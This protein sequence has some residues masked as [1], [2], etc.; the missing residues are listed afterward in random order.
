MAVLSHFLAPDSDELSM[1][2]AQ[3]SYSTTNELRRRLANFCCDLH[4]WETRMIPNGHMIK[5]CT[6]LWGLIG[7][8]S[9]MY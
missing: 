1:A 9:L 5:D 3:I 4:L 8:Y 6:V 7:T 2:R